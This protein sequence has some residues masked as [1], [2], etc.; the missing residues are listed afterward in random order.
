M[1]LYRSA[2]VL[3]EFVLEEWRESLVK[4]P[5][6]E[7]IRSVQLSINARGKPELVTPVQFAPAWL[8]VRKYSA[9]DSIEIIIH[10]HLLGIH[11]GNKKTRAYHRRQ[12]EMERKLLSWAPVVVFLA[13]SAYRVFVFRAARTV[14]C[15][16]R[17]G[18]CRVCLFEVGWKCVHEILSEKSSVKVADVFF[19]PPLSRGGSSYGHQKISA[20]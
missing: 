2:R 14:S 12:I 13:P 17:Y 1:H 7:H 20:S 15:L 10:Y 18:I 4:V 6:E 16:E 19:L 3:D 8:R 11:Q 9:V 5:V